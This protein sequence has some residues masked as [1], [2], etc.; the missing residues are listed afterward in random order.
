[1]IWEF[2][3]AEAKSPSRGLAFGFKNFEFNHF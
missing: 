2:Y 3:N 1:M